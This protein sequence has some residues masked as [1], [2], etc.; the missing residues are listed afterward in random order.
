VHS[1][2]VVRIGRRCDKKLELPSWRTWPGSKQSTISRSARFTMPLVAAAFSAAVGAAAEAM[3][4]RLG[5][6]RAAIRP[7]ALGS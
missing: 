3:I 5:A 2:K 7:S 1:D 6:N 4:S